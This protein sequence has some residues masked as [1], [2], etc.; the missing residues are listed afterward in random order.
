MNRGRLGS[1]IRRPSDG[2]SIGPTVG[3]SNTF[4]NSIGFPS[5]AGFRS[6]FC[7]AILDVIEQP[8]IKVSCND[9]VRRVGD[10]GQSS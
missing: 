7:N 2:T 5:G 10:G 1:T 4:C 3:G 9:L 6:G 8:S